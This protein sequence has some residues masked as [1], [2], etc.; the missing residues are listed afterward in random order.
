MAEIM[1]VGGVV[2]IGM[3]LADSYAENIP[4]TKEEKFWEHL[5]NSYGIAFVVSNSA[6]A[7]YPVLEGRLCPEEVALAAGLHD[8]GCALERNQL[9]HELRSAQYILDNWRELN[10]ASD[11]HAVYRVAQM[12]KPHFMVHEQW[13]DPA[14]QE[15]ASEFKPLD[16]ALLLPRTW[17]EAI[18]M[19]AGMVSVHQDLKSYK[20]RLDEICEEARTLD[21]TSAG[22]PTL[23]RALDKGYARVLETCGRVYK[24]HAGTLAPKEV[25]AYGFI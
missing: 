17:S 18:V 1:D 2:A 9:F 13:I 8:V 10:L 5:G 11:E 4:K 16:P 19:F 6:I 20:Q 25:C 15:A 3:D 23:G 21:F 14:N 22:D 24:L 12:V 7:S